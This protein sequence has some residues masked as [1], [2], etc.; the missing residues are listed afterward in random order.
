MDNRLSGLAVAVAI[1]LPIYSAGAQNFGG[2]DAVGNVIEDDARHKLAT[3]KKRLS[4]GW[5]DWKKKVQNENGFSIGVDYTALGLS[6][7]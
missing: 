6:S 2:P 1:A 4:Q 3:I 7:S 5:F